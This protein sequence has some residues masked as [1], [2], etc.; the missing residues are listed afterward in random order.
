MIEINPP[1]NSWHI[2]FMFGL[3]IWIAINSFDY[4]ESIP[5]GKLRNESGTLSIQKVKN[6]NALLFTG[7]GQNGICKFHG[8]LKKE[9]T[10]VHK[11]RAT[12]ELDEAN[13]IFKITIN[14]LMIFGDNDIHSERNYY[15][16]KISICFILFM[17]Y[18]TFFLLKKSARLD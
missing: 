8:C 2:G 13:R 10:S 1:R 14:G 6:K 15:A 18:L 16:F 11:K 7:D 3:V 5:K 9:L 12:V 4:F 17:V